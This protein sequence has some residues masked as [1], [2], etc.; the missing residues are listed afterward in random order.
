MLVFVLAFFCLLLAC[1]ST[2]EEAARDSLFFLARSLIPALFPFAVLS[3]FV[4]TA[5]LVPC[6]N[7][8]LQKTASLFSISQTLLPAYLLGLFCGFPIGAYAAASLLEAGLCE[9]TAAHRSAS[10]SNN[11]SAA[12][13]FGTATL[14]PHPHAAII[15]LASQTAATL[16]I[17]LLSKKQPIPFTQTLN[18]PPTYL[19]LLADAIGKAG[20]A[21][22]SLSAFVVF[23]AVVTKA[24][25]LVGLPPCITLILEPTSAVRYAAGL[26]QTIGT[27]LSLAFASFALGFSGLSVIM[28]TQAIFHGKLPLK[29][30]ILTRLAIALVSFAITFFTA[31]LLRG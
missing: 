20:S 31:H 6:Q 2:L 14:F 5:S 3:R 27:P 7:K 9:E 4:L 16:F 8:I 24:L 29:K 12:F 19:S 25:L 17:S 15:L 13:L 23:F 30:Q 21:M 28:Q 1:H 26:S 11:A 18:E 10:L 22:L